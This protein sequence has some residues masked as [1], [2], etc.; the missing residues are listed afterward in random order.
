MKMN[1]NDERGIRQYLRGVSDTEEAAR[2][3]GFVQHGHISTYQ[4]VMNVVEMS[5]QLDRAL[6]LHSDR[7]SR[8][9]GAFLHDFYLYDWHD[10]T[11]NEGLHGFKH[12]AR[13]LAK[14]QEMFTLNPTEQNIIISHMWPLTFTHIPKCREAVIVCLSDK[15]CALYETVLKDK[16]LFD[17]DL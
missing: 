15:L 8:V 3:K 13:A 10:P 7:K 2:M 1:A 5:Y 11:S 9:R 16:C 6:H 17:I 4:H 12:P 14:A